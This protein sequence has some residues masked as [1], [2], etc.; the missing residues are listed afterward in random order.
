M[1]Q[2]K[3]TQP[4]MKTRLIVLPAGWYQQLLLSLSL[5]L[6]EKRGEGGGRDDGLVVQDR[7]AV[8]TAFQSIRKIE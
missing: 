8:E 7:C 3:T 1:E 5:V 6:V 4:S 2:G